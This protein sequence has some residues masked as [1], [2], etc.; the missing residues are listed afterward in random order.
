MLFITHDLAVVAQVADYVA[1]MYTGRIVEQGPVREVLTNPRHPYTQRLLAASPTLQP[2]ALQPIPGTVPALT[3]LPPG[4]AFAPRCDLRREEC[5]A[6]VPALLP[7][8][9]AGMDAAV[10]SAPGQEEHSARCVLVADEVK[11][12]QEVTP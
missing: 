2:G 11:S 12:E 7:V 5:D 6:A 4:C 1:V 3:D 10:R 9:S 8:A